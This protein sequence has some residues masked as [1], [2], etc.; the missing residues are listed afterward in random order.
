M[1]YDQNTK[2][3]YLDN[4]DNRVE[5][6]EAYHTELFE[7]QAKG[8]IIVADDKGYPVAIEPLPLTDDE[9][10]SV[11]VVSKVKAM[12]NLKKLGVL[13]FVLDSM[14][15]EK[16]DSDI[17]ILWDFSETFH[18]TDHTLIDFCINKMGLDEKGIDNI[19]L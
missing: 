3:F 7:A 11:M 5:I 17:R 9:R 1:F 6:T 12:Q 18:R 16:R 13:N 19:F 8:K 4:S 14:D 2:G 10:R 15:A